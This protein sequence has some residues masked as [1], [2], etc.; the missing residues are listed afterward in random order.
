M[1][2]RASRRFW[3]CYRGL[4]KHV[5]QLA[6]RSYDLLKSNPAHPSLHFK[7]I[8]QFRSARIGLHYRAL[9]VE[10]GDDLVWFWIRSHADYD[11]LLGREPARR[12]VRP[13]G[14]R[15]PGKRTPRRHS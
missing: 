15:Q 12:Q 7:A 1:T 14:A 11:K 2:H 13:S 3:R 9:A 5:R 8:G 10:A 6:D 4:P